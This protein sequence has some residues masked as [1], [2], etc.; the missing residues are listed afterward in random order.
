M[1]PYRTF[2]QRSFLIQIISNNIN[3]IS[4]NFFKR[5]FYTLC[6]NIVIVLHEHDTKILIENKLQLLNRDLYQFIDTL[7]ILFEKKAHETKFWNKN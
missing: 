7:H 4:I 6:V 2:N 5:N 1:L 3:S